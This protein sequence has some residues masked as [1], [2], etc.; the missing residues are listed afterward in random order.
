MIG[1]PLE[2]FRILPVLAIS[3]LLGLTSQAY[4]LLAGS[5]HRGIKVRRGTT[6]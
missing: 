2:Y 3:V 6:K 1:H 4:G 5:F